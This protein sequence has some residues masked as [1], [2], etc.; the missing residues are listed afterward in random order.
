MT[1]FHVLLKHLPECS[2]YNPAV[3]WCGAFQ[4]K[5]LTRTLRYSLYTTE[6]YRL[7]EAQ[8]M[9]QGNITWEYH[10]WQSPTGIDQALN[11]RQC[12]FHQNEVLAADR[13]F[14]PQRRTRSLSTYSWFL[15]QLAKSTK[16]GKK[17]R[18]LIIWIKKSQCL[19]N[20]GKKKSGT[21]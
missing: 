16:K 20:M 11:C 19:Y 10:N 8:H 12:I 21:H 9:D 4:K 15:S 1:L 2:I 18:W 7:S 17:G 14:Y 13:Y 3:N 6:L 5:T